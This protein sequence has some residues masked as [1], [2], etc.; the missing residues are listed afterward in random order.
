MRISQIRRSQWVV[1]IQVESHHRR[2]GDARRYR[3]AARSPSAQNCTREFGQRAVL[4][5][6]PI[7]VEVLILRDIY[8]GR[9]S[10]SVKRCPRYAAMQP[11]TKPAIVPPSGSRM[12]ATIASSRRESTPYSA[13]PHA[14]SSERTAK[15]AAQLMIVMVY[16]MTRRNS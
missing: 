7:P 16:F 13:A 6:P 14:A 11:M 10:F 4:S 9:V 12:N 5:T 3:V 2:T 1:R 15:R 8:F